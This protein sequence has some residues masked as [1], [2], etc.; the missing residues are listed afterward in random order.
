[1]FFIENDENQHQAYGSPECEMRRMLDVK[2]ALLQQGTNTPLI[3][4]RYNPHAFRVD[5]KL[6][7]IN[8]IDRIKRLIRLIE[9]LSSKPYDIPFSIYYLF[10]DTNTSQTNDSNIH[11]IHQ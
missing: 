10:Y 5:N 9:E 4:I 3:W 1:M 8:Q 11:Y 6:T 7:K 2:S